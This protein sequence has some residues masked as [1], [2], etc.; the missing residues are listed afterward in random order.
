MRHQHFQVMLAMCAMMALGQAA[1]AAPRTYNVT[2][3]T[4]P[5]VGHTAGPFSLVF[6][7][8][9]GGGVGDANNIV[10]VTDVDFHGGAPAGSPLLWGGASGSLETSVNLTDNNLVNLFAESFSPGSMLTFSVSLTAQ[11][12]D[13]GVPDHLSMYILD[14]S[15]NRLPTLAPYADVFIGLDL[16]SAAPPPDAFGSDPSRSIIAGGPIAIAA[17]VLGLVDRIPTATTASI[18]PSPNVAGWNNSNVSVSLVS[19]D[20]LGGSGVKQVMCSVSGAQTT[21]STTVAGS[22]A[23]VPITIEGVST[24]TFGAQDNAGNIET[25]QVLTVRVDK[26]RPAIT[27]SRSPLSNGNG[28]NNSAV[29]ISFQCSDSLSGLAAGSPPA[30]TIV[31]TAAA[32]QSV[33]GTCTD[34]AGNSAS[35]TLSGINIDFE[36]PQISVSASL[37]A[38]WPPNNKLVP[39]VFSGSMTDA[40]AGIDP[41]SATFTIVDEY[42]QFQPSGVISVLP[43]GSYSFTVPLMASRLGT[44][45]DGRRYQVI[46]SVSDK[47][48]NRASVSTVVTVPHDQGK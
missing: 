13:G 35:L 29:T 34:L 14:H 11:D 22:S 43:N 21:A 20:N 31:S 25:A 48:G 32:A 41:T 5:L 26:T 2:F 9:D 28:W 40:L 10:A 6:V 39:D 7:T 37:P 24:I 8:T 23:N 19:V 15:G 3:N 16:G 27:G 30:P 42:G 45:M 1:A 4:A 46:V 18:V 36:P 44:D 33:Q 12:D 47:A 38:L 17:P